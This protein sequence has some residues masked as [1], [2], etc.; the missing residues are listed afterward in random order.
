MH[1][2]WPN[3]VAISEKQHCQL[4]SLLQPVVDSNARPYEQHRCGSANAIRIRL[5]LNAAV[6]LLPWWNAE[7]GRRPMNITR[8]LLRLWLVSSAL[9]AISIGAVTWKELPVIPESGGMPKRWRKSSTSRRSA[10]CQ[11]AEMAAAQRLRRRG[12][13]R[14]LHRQDCDPTK[15]KHSYSYIPTQQDRQDAITSGLQWALIPP[16]LLFAIG[17]SLVWAAPGFFRR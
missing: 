11:P 2:A 6:F 13:L 17:G 15:D 7:R 16:L 3:P 12:L 5:Y 10:G 9:W 8:G 1:H 14:A 4:S